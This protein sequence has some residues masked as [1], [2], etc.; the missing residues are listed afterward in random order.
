MHEDGQHTGE[1]AGQQAGEPRACAFCGAQGEDAAVE[2]TERLGVVVH[3]CARCRE[4]F[5]GAAAPA[6]PA[7]PVPGPGPGLP[8]TLGEQTS[9]VVAHVRRMA[10]RVA[11]RTW[12]EEDCARCG[13]AVHVHRDAAG[14]PVRLAADAV[15]ATSVPVADRWR[16]RDGHAEAVGHDDPEQVGA[17]VLHDLVCPA[18]PVPDNPRLARAWH[19]NLAASDTAGTG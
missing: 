9:A 14:E 6:A 15:L 1:Q 8:P 5:A 18:H 7:D 16:V 12:R 19:A 11:E 3:V 17:R 13:A 4:R 10:R 2:A